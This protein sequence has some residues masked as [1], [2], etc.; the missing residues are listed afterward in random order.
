MVRCMEYI[1]VDLKNMWAGADIELSITGVC[2]AERK[3]ENLIK[4]VMIAKRFL[5]RALFFLIYTIRIKV[6]EF[7]LLL[8]I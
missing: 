7:K 2:F 6:K 3:I 1:T 5:T 8:F 4:H